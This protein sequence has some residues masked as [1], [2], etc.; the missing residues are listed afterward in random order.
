MA[1]NDGQMADSGGE[2]DSLARLEAAL[3]RI[4]QHAQLGA[5]Q[6]VALQ[7][8]AP[9]PQPQAAEMIASRLDALI[10]QVR[11]GLNTGRAASED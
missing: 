5:L 2:P 3:D 6:A 8:G 11:A 1:D 10:G 7:A 9:V 4:A